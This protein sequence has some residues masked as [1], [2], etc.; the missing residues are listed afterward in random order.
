MINVDTIIT[1]PG[2]AYNF[3]SETDRSMFEITK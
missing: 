2:G 1:L 3:G